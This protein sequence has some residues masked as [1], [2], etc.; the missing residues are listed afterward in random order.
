MFPLLT[1]VTTR[2]EVNFGA[3]AVSISRVGIQVESLSWL[4]GAGFGAALTAF[5]GQ[6]FGAGKTDR[7]EKGFR[8][9]ALFL[10]AFGLWVTA[11]MWFGGDI[12]FAIFLPEHINDPEMRRI[13]I[14]HMRIMAV[15][16]VFANLEFAAANAFRGKS[17][18]IPPSVI[19]ISSNIILVPMAYLLSLTSLGLL[20]IWAARSITS[21]LRGLIIL[22]WYLLAERKER[23]ANTLFNPNLPK[24]PDDTLQ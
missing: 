15:C 3:F 12:I 1:M 8:Y 4:V 23:L 2:F 17:R 13:F 21:S 9:T 11:I 20:G 14:A 16:Q 24:Y 19:N 10:T 6:N 5:V 7:I 18:T 22:I